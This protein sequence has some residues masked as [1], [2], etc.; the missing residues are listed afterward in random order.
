MHASYELPMPDESESCRTTVTLP[1]E[2]HELLL[3]L[4]E[5]KH[6]S[7]AWMIREAVREY[8]DQQTPLFSSTAT[9]P[10]TRRQ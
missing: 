7:L 2:H 6:V 9:S 10:V 1:R 8:L 3:R 4:A 5:T